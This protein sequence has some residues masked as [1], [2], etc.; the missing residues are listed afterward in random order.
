MA[1]AAEK[2]TAKVEAK[3]EKKLTAVYKQANKELSAKFKSYLI[4]STIRA[5]EL[6]EEYNQIAKKQGADS[7]EAKEALEHYKGYVERQTLHSAKFQAQIEETAEQISHRNETALKYVNDE[8]ATVYTAHYNQ[9]AEMA[10]EYTGV[11]FGLLNTATVKKMVTEENKILLPKKTVNIPKDVAWNTKKINNQILQGII[12]GESINKIAKRF[13][14][15][16][17]RNAES[18]MRNART[19]ITSAQN[20]GTLDQMKQQRKMGIHVMKQWMATKDKRTRDSHADLDGQKAE[21]DEPFITINGNEIM[22]PGDPA[23]A[24]EE[25]YNCR[26]TL[27]FYYPDFDYSKQDSEED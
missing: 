19:M 13:T 1:T 15:V 26:C 12:Q 11:S 18:R 3:L 9:T 5:N 10:E 16:T 4:K 17:G 7:P 25:V 8:M 27:G 24:P 14:A 21:L 20:Q 6:L 2:T 23:A 22:Q